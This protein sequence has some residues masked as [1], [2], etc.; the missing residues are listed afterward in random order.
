MDIFDISHSAIFTLCGGVGFVSLL[1]ALELLPGSGVWVSSTCLFIGFLAAALQ[2]AESSEKAATRVLDRLGETNLSSRYLKDSPGAQGS[3]Y[4]HRLK[5]EFAGSQAEN[6]QASERLCRL[7]DSMPLLHKELNCIMDLFMRDCVWWW[8]QDIFESPAFPDATRDMLMDSLAKLVERDTNSENSADI[9]EL[10][11]FRLCHALVVH[12]RVTKEARNAVRM[13]KLED[14]RS[15]LHPACASPQAELE[16][17]RRL[18]ATICRYAVPPGEL[19]GAMASTMLPEILATGIIIPS[20]ASVSQPYFIHSQI[21]SFFSP[22][23]YKQMVT[24]P[25]KFELKQ[26]SFLRKERKRSLDSAQRQRSRK[27]DPLT[28]NADS[29]LTARAKPLHYYYALVHMGPHLMKSKRAPVGEDDRLTFDLRATFPIFQEH[30]IS[31]LRIDLY[32][33][34]PMSVVKMVGYC[35]IPLGVL[36]EARESTKAYTLSVSQLDE[37]ELLVGAECTVESFTAMFKGTFKN[38]MTAEH[39]GD[40]LKHSESGEHLAVDDDDGDDG[41]DEE[42]RETKTATAALQNAKPVKLTMARVLNN[43]QDSLGPFTE[44]LMERDATAALQGWMNIQSFRL[45]FPVKATSEDSGLAQEALMQCGRIMDLHFKEDSPLRLRISPDLLLKLI[46]DRDSN[47]V[48][49]LCTTMLE[50]HH[51]IFS[52]LERLYFRDFLES[53]Y[54]AEYHRQRKERYQRLVTEH[55]SSTKSSPLGSAS[56]GS[57]PQDDLKGSRDLT[58]PSQSDAKGESKHLT[59]RISED[60]VGTV[61][62]EN[63]DDLEDEMHAPGSASMN[64]HSAIGAAMQMLKE[65][66]AIVNQQLDLKQTAHDR[67]LLLRESQQLHEEMRSLEAV[68]RLSNTQFVYKVRVL[69]TRMIQ[70]RGQI[71][72]SFLLDVSRVLTKTGVVDDNYQIWRTFISFQDFHRVMKGIFAKVEKIPFPQRGLFRKHSPERLKQIQSDLDKYMNMLLTD[73]MLAQARPV[74]LFLAPV[75]RAEARGTGPRSHKESA[76]HMANAQAER[77]RESGER[78]SA[79]NSPRRTNEPTSA[80]S[81][82]SRGASPR[83]LKPPL[84]PRRNTHHPPSEHEMAEQEAEMFQKVTEIVDTAEDRW[85]LLASELEGDQVDSLSGS[86]LSVASS[87]ALLDVPSSSSM[88]NGGSSSGSKSTSAGKGSAQASPSQRK[89]G[90]TSSPREEQNPFFDEDARLMHETLSAVLEEAF[91]L[92][93]RNQWF[94]RRVLAVFKGTIFRRYGQTIN[95]EV[96]KQLNI[97]QSEEYLESY[98]RTIR[99]SV[100]PDGTWCAPYPAPTEKLKLAMRMDAIRALGRAM[101][102]QVAPLVSNVFWTASMTNLINSCSDP[103]FNKSLVY[104]MLDAMVQQLTDAGGR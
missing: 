38:M 87:T 32:R 37:T 84:S 41:D 30:G 34:D 24:E 100:W 72:T 71:T 79:E 47:N 17:V 5:T 45:A 12:L 83:E 94:R 65:K 57:T 54:Y 52:A 11:I 27:S 2:A 40:Q 22:K 19:T 1:Y 43:I 56:G 15:S 49:S 23:R 55:S 66:R 69:N 26:L 28:D 20:V 53:E 60:S 6:G 21:V 31:E 46:Q 18:S 39:H 73:E 3:E 86:R 42:D 103:L 33:Y 36:L 74:Q 59:K 29:V 91:D 51:E 16:H 50:I 98:L 8:Y 67:R 99:E 48:A 85:L 104:T 82:S 81:P 90:T 75:R 101:P 13:G 58:E 14:F 97:L 80:S 64:D 77:W 63:V 62:L 4:R 7:K 88:T 68:A 70:Y 102:E 10:V 95:K 93:H 76:A 96:I 92:N 89:G 78:R 61:E 35:A 25:M 9:A 44:Y